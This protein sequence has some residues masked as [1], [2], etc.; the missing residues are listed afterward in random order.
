MPLFC[1]VHGST[2][3]ASGWDLLVPELRKRGHEVVCPSLPADRPDAPAT[4]YAMVIAEA[5][6]DSTEPPIVVGHSVSGLFLPIVPSLCRVRMCWAGC[7]A[8]STAEPA[9]A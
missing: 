4:L 8:R 2:Q 6:R 3:D 7:E 1:L 9:S 5:V